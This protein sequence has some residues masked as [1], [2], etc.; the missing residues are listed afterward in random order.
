MSLS[1]VLAVGLA[2]ACTSSSPVG[3][4]DSTSA[5]AGWP[6]P[7]NTGVPPGTALTDYSGPCLITKAGAVIDG[8]TV[9]CDLEIHAANVMIKNS[10]VNGLVFSDV[11]LP[12]GKTW[13][14]TLQDSEVDGGPVQRAVVSDGNLTVVRA[15]I[16]G[17][18]TGVHC[19]ENALTCVVQDSWL[20]GQYLPPDQPWHLGG[21]QSNGGTNIVLSHNTIVC[22][23]AANALGEGCTGDLNLIPD[24]AP[25]S[26]VT[27]ENNFLG[28]NIDG[29]YCT[30]GGEKSTSPYPHADHVVYRNNTFERGVNREC[31]SYGPVTG[32][33]VDGAGNE[34]IDNT[35]QDDGSAVVPEL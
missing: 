8:K 24:F 14:F 25:V 3:Q 7:T 27:I 9:N 34:W 17:G 11:D 29:S 5:A 16:Y 2:G 32:F 35:W 1:L 6:G 30:Y 15:N 23:H 10:K 18:E 21:F 26:H 4:L 33:D 13:S 12:N 22:D 31:G 28:A 20:H 19:S